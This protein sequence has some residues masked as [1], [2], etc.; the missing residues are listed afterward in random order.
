MG[1]NQT[2]F[3]LKGCFHIDKGK[4]NKIKCL[5]N[6]SKDGQQRNWSIISFTLPTFYLM[7]GNDIS[8]FKTEG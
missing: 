1:G 8:F 3:E 2:D 7:N 4:L 5:E 6:V